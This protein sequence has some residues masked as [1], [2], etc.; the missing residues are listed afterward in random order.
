MIHKPEWRPF[1][2]AFPLLIIS[3]GLVVGLLAVNHWVPAKPVVMCLWIS[4]VA[5]VFDST[6]TCSTAFRVDNYH[7]HICHQSL[8][9]WNHGALSHWVSWK[10][11]AWAQNARGAFRHVSVRVQSHVINII[12]KWNSMYTVYTRIPLCVY[13]LPPVAYHISCCPNIPEISLIHF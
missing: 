6:P 3:C 4:F 5:D 11:Y 13:I 2:E 1:R 8:L 7:D 9:L 12:Y 10:I